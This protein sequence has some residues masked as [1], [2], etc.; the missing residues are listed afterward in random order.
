MKRA[1]A[2]ET[3]AKLLIRNP[4][5]ITGIISQARSKKKPAGE[6]QPEN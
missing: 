4:F 5:L 2:L 3:G 6:P 1:P